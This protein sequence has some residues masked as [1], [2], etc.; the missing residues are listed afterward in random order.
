M[1]R[2]KE[3]PS[4]GSLVV[5][6]VALALVWPAAA[7]A[8]PPLVDDTRVNTA[9]AIR[10]TTR[11]RARRASPCGARPYAPGSTTPGRPPASRLHLRISS[12]GRWTQLQGELGANNNGDPTLA[13]NN[14]TG[15]FFYGENAT[16]GGNPAIGVA[17]S[18]D[19]CQTFGAA[20][21][22]SA[23]SSG[24][25]TVGNLTTLSDKPSIAVDNSGG[26]DNGNV[27]VCWTRFIDTS[28]PSGRAGGY[29][30]AS[31]FRSINGGPSYVNEQI[32]QA[33]GPAP[34]R[35][36]RQSRSQRPGARGLGPTGPAQRPE[37]SGS[38]PR[39]TAG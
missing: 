26:A 35:V 24:L 9:T 39:R 22:A 29:E 25:N 16:I 17:R 23:A 21:D 10:A 33:Q 34:F 20:V 15:T 5:I 28:N 4:A 2:P 27:Y 7:F 36:G 31:F 19:N 37:T 30:R 12:C 6:A 11:R 3:D 13:I 14:K 8:Q 32:I 1:C 38:W 18:T